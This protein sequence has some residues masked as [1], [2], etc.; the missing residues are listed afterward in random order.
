MNVIRLNVK[1]YNLQFENM[2][3]N[4]YRENYESI[5]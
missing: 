5:E 3:E 4:I 1:I 2:K